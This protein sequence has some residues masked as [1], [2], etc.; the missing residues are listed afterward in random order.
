MTQARPLPGAY[1][2]APEIAIRTGNKELTSVLPDV[3]ELKVTLEK[4]QLGGF[5]L[6]LANADPRTVLGDRSVASQFKYSDSALFDV[7]NAVSIEMGYAGRMRRMLVGEVASFSPS[8]PASG[9]PTLAIT[10]ADRLSRLRRFKPGAN[11]PK[12]YPNVHDWEI[13]QK[14]AKRHDLDV[15]VTKEGPQ[16]PIVMQK[17]Q[18]DLE[19]LLDRAKRVGFDCF[20]DV[21]PGTK[22]D[23][24]YFI[25]PK[26][27]RD[28]R[29]S[30]VFAFRWGESL[31]SFTPRMTV[32]RQVAKVTVRGW[33]PRTKQKIEYTAQ[34]G[35]LPKTGGNGRTGAEIVSEKLGAKEERIV[36]LPVASRDE[37]RKLAIGLL[38]RTAN[39]FLTGSGEVIGDPDLRPGVIVQLDGLGRRFSGNYTVRKTEHQFGASGYVTTFEVER[40]REQQRPEAAS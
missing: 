3:I 35:D 20:I 40:L 23:R 2:Y 15:E 8:F 5:S 25:K 31:Q 36:D 6:Q 29:P 18:D 38:E 24:L 4:D 22:R 13:A 30:D 14:I 27:Q 21:D 19:F 17:D 1:A 34:V 7:G 16:H 28:A 33:D 32:G 39:E 12:S 11:D 37:A 9:L 26:D 10:G